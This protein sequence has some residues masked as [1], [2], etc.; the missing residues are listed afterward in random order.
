[1]L[2]IELPLRGQAEPAGGALQQAHPQLGFEARDLLAHRRLGHTEH[3][4]R[5]GETALLHYCGE[6]PHQLQFD[7]VHIFKQSFLITHLNED[8]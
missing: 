2:H 3:L 7:I 1:M 4:G 5:P 8:N 6:Q